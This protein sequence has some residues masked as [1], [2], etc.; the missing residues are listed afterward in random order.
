MSK[1]KQ[2]RNEKT[3]ESMIKVI[4]LIAN[5][6]DGKYHVTVGSDDG[7]RVV[8]IRVEMID[9]LAPLASEHP[10]FPMKE[11]RDMPGRNVVFKVP[12]GLRKKYH[13]GDD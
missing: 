2:Q 5:R 7:G 11:I 9:P 8:E 4:R 12:R 6:F 13:K 10:S 3:E 1:S